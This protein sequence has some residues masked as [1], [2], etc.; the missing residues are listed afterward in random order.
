MKRIKY[1]KKK[2]KK[3]KVLTKQSF[4]STEINTFYDSI[5]HIFGIR[6]IRNFVFESFLIHR[7]LKVEAYRLKIIEFELFILKY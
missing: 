6:S 7:W 2:E 5:A 4:Y 3:E 1:Q